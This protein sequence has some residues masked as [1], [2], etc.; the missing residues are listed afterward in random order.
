MTSL[1]IRRNRF[2]LSE[3]SVNS[4]GLWMAWQNFIRVGTGLASVNQ[5]FPS[6]QGLPYIRPKNKRLVLRCLA[7]IFT[8]QIVMCNLYAVVCLVKPAIFMVLAMLEMV[9]LY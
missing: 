4:A 2:E 7:K 3:D 9:S 8:D 6:R 1:R 5:K